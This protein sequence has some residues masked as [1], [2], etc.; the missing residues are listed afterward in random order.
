MSQ[1]Q[2]IAD[3]VS[4]L[5]QRVVASEAQSVQA[6]AETDVAEERYAALAE[7]MNRGAEPHLFPVRRSIIVFERGDGGRI[8]SAAVGF[9]SAFIVREHVVGVQLRGGLG[10]LDA[11]GE[12]E[13]RMDGD[14]YSILLSG[15]RVLLADMQP[16]EVD[17]LRAWLVA[18]VAPK[19]KR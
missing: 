15:G 13:S 5:E 18:P 19:V 17:Q 7:T 2:N 3:Y 14:C 11:T 16:E 8:E 6:R 10:H 4:E 12:L 9:A 1:S